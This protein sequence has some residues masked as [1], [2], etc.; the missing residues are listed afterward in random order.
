MK[1]HMRDRLMAPRGLKQFW[2]ILLPPTMIISLIVVTGSKGYLL[3]K[4][5]PSHTY[6]PSVCDVSGSLISNSE[7]NSSLRAKLLTPYSCGF[8]TIGPTAT[9]SPF[10]LAT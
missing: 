5:T 8:G 9:A 6:A 7:I 2:Y 4:K 1:H 10:W 3:D